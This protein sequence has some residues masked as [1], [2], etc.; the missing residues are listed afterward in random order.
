[1][2]IRHWPVRTRAV[3][4]AAIP[5]L[6]TVVLLTMLHMMAR[7]SDASKSSEATVK[8][9]IESI[10][11]SAE[12]PVI[13]GNYDLL[14]PLIDAALNEPE[15]A[16]VRVVSPDDEVLIEA[17]VD[18]F[19]QVDL[20]SVQIFRKT[21]LRDVVEL[22]GFSEFGELMVASQELA[23]VEVGMTNHFTRERDLSILYQSLISGLLV[24]LL[25]GMMGRYMAL[26]IVRP[27]ERV[28]EFISNLADGAYWQRT[29]ASDGAE[30]GNLQ[31]NSN[32][33]AETL[34]QAHAEHQEFTARLIDE[35]KL[36]R[37]ASEAKSKFLAM[38]SHE[39]RTPLNGA[40]GMLQLLDQKQTQGEFET[41]KYQAEQSLILLNQL[42]DDIMVVAD[43]SKQSAP[44]IPEYCQLNDYLEPVF[45]QLR[46]RAMSHGLSFI[47]EIGVTLRQA[48][49]LTYPG[50]IRQILRHLT[51]NALKFTQQGMV[52]V[53]ILPADD[54]LQVIVTDTGIGIPEE[55][56]DEILQPF[57]Q[58]ESDANRQFGGVGL[59]LTITSHVVRM[60]GG[61]LEFAP[62]AGGGSVVRVR[63]PAVSQMSEEPRE[64][65]TIDNK[66]ASI[67]IV[68]DNEVNLK[69]AEK[70]LNKVAPNMVISSV[71]SGEAALQ[72]IERKAFDLIVMDCQMPGM[73]GF[74]TSQKLRERH[75]EGVIVACTANTTDG[76][77]ARCLGAGM[78]DYMPKP[79]RLEGIRHM[80]TRWLGV[81][82]ESDSK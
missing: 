41:E 49:V 62:Q 61:T 15:I 73:D 31:E 47:A 66:Q 19:D 81:A 1:M 76:I 22:D 40:M 75:F 34:E 27:I 59:G 33:L 45:E 55:S 12:Y 80:L 72:V 10:S 2:R 14:M 50:L 8:L 7:W 6:V 74:E 78:N 17:S 51:D 9:M 13:S 65:A 4:L 71:L 35:K 79:L 23:K 63:L 30:V 26:M 82:S 54:G 56:Y 64:R 36:A 38:M 67:L 48:P 29:D 5:A 39:L 77:E 43:T 28:A 32:R 52:S 46:L 11:A 44:V 21:L 68:E 18:G 53:S 60:L 3:A 24:V 20:D 69:V 37:S 25:A 58:L 42:L 70:M 16:L 57:S